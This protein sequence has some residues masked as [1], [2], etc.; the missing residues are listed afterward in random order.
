MGLN[1]L[2]ME[3]RDEPLF[4]FAIPSM[5]HYLSFVNIYRLFLGFLPIFRNNIYICFERMRV[6]RLTMA[7]GVIK[8]AQIII[9]LTNL[10]LN[11]ALWRIGR[12]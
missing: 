4:P 5:R 10:N 9:S 12:I 3:R 7:V 6:R 2:R 8:T 11:W 1:F